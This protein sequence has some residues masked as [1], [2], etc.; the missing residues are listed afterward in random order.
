MRQWLP[1]QSSPLKK[2]Q[3]TISC[4][5]LV[6]LANPGNRPDFNSTLGAG[7]GAAANVGL[8]L[9][10]LTSF[11]GFRSKDLVLK[12]QGTSSAE[13]RFVLSCAIYPAPCTLRVNR[14]DESTSQLHEIRFVGHRTQLAKAREKKTD[15]RGRRLASR[16]GLRRIE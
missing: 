16:D 3:Q 13:V 5:L 1:R 9:H 10:L 7:L 12:E 4:L 11:P 14:S 15:Q 6:S 2:K 8:D